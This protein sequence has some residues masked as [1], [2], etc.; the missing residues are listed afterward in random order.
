[1]PSLFL[2]TDIPSVID[3]WYWLAFIWFYLTFPDITA[4][5]IDLEL[6]KVVKVI[7]KCSVYEWMEVQQ[8]ACAHTFCVL[9]HDA[10]L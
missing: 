6:L 7:D 8:I 9:E 1:M 5:L 3:D 4:S 2:T 10:S